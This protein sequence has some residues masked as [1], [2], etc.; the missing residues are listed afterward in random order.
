MIKEKII[1]TSK[2]I[3]VIRALKKR[4]KKIVFTNG[5]FDILHKGHIKLLK[6]AKSLGD[7]LVV[8]INSDSSVKKIKGRK[9]P[10]NSA[11]DRAVVL[12]SISFVD[13]ITTFS[14]P[15]PAR[16]I[17][18]LN[19][20]I[21]VKGGDWD[22]NEIVGSRYIKSR[23]GKVCSVSLAKGYSTSGIINAITKRVR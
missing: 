5:C 11:Q 2:L 18:R 15:D 17:K 6:K 19:P 20:D 8:A 10:F 14:E 16:I 21:L 1:N 3:T 9:R 4:G 23:G 7:I 12:S 22:K 13:F